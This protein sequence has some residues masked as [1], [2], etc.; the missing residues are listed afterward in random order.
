MLDWRGLALCKRTREK[1]HREN[2]WAGENCLVW[3]V[4]L[5]L[6]FDPVGEDP[7]HVDEVVTDD[8][9]SNPTVHPVVAFVP[10]AIE[11]MTPLDHAD[12]PFATGSPFLPIAEPALLLLLLPLR[13]LGGAIGNADALDSFFVRRLFVAGRVEGRIGRNQARGSPQLP[14][15]R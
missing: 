5:A 14:L 7:P 9:E 12:A 1:A 13:A 8:A 10:A 3:G 2:R 6:I 4:K 11:S 15:V